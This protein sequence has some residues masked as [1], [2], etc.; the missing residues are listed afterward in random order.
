MNKLPFLLIGGTVEQFSSHLN[1]SIHLICMSIIC[2]LQNWSKIE[3]RKKTGG[4]GGGGAFQ[5]RI[6]ALKSSLL[7][8]LHIYQGKGKIFCV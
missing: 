4:G 7:N 6:Q 2:V 1:V 3:V 5:K 8:K